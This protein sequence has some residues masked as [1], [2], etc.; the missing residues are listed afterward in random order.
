MQKHMTKVGRLLVE[1]GREEGR[2]EGIE[3]FILDNLEENIPEDR[4]LEKLQRRF[5]MKESE[6]KAYFE[7][8]ALA[9]QFRDHV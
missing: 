6:A 5:R 7:K 3:A 9:A 8:Y 1:E 2:E 4:I